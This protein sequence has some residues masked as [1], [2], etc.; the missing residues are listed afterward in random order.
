MFMFE[1][2]RMQQLA[3]IDLSL[4]INYLHLMY[5]LSIQRMTVNG[6]HAVI[7]SE[8]TTNVHGKHPTLCRVK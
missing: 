3:V 1:V 2:C 4:S 5:T 7:Q 8:T 6:A